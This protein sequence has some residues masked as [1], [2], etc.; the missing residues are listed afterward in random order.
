VLAGAALVASALVDQP[1]RYYRDAVVVEA[2]RELIWDVLTDFEAYDEWNPYVTRANGIASE[3]ADIELTLDA[4][5]AEAEE[6]A[7]EV[8]IVHPRRKLEWRTRVLVPGLLDHEQIFR[9]LPLGPRRFRL[10]QEARFEGLLAP[11]AN[12]DGE[13]RGLVTMIEALAERAQ[14]RYQSTSE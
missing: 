8:L 2:P 11:F 12:L 5:D 6:A 1:S 3:G 4:S 9:V 13:R 10:V 7:A 14:A